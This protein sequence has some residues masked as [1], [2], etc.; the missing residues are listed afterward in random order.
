MIREAR[1]AAGMTQAEV[2]NRLGTSQSVI[3]RLERPGTN[4]TWQ[5]LIRA[6]RAT[7]HELELSRRTQPHAATDLGQLRERISL[8]AQER[9]QTFQRSQHN[10]N[11]LR[12]TAQRLGDDRS[13][14][15]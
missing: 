5:T 11:R 9:L 13:S 7:G 3:A 6:L 10:L 1:V 2:A 12:A 8:T 4:P 14:P 15:A